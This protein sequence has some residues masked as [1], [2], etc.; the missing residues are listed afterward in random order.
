MDLNEFKSYCLN[1]KSV[2]E[3]FPFDDK[4]LVLKVGSK[5]FT[6]TNINKPILEINLKC[7]PI[8]SQDLRKDYSSMIML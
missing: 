5:M 3:T 2:A 7:A 8:M 4:T 6:L 1:K